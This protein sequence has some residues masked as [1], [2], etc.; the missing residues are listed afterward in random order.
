MHASAARTS[1]SSVPEIE[2]EFIRISLKNRNDS[3]ADDTHKDD[4]GNNIDL[5]S[6]PSGSKSILCDEIDS[7]IPT[8]FNDDNH[9]FHINFM[10]SMQNIINHDKR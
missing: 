4:G 9:I 10:Q 8:D 3:I 2:R 5:M 6:Q 1:S 7:D